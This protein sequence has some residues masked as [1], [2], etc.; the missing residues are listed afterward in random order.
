MNIFV[1]EDDNWD[2]YAL[3]S[4]YISKN[5][6]PENVRIHHVYGKKLPHVN[7]ITNDNDF[8]I[9]RRNIDDKEPKKSYYE[10]IKNMNI[11]F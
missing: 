8:N 4:K 6:L 7:K 10:I 1:V 3:I 5:Y 2:N 9:Y 11:W